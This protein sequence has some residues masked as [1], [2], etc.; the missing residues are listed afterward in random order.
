MAE[1]YV[2]Y[3]TREGAAGHRERV[4]LLQ[5]QEYKYEQ[6]YVRHSSTHGVSR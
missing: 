6:K 2:G 5:G 4:G 1:Q 3:D